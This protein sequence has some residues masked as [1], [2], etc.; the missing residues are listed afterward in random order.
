MAAFPDGRHRIRLVRNHEVR[1]SPGPPIEP[2]RPYDPLAGGGT[3]TVIV[4]TRTRLPTGGFVSLSGTHTNCAGGPTPWGSWVT[5]EE[6]TLGTDA[7]FTKPH[8]YTF[9]IPADA[10][11]PVNPV[12]LTAMGRFV[13]EALAVDPRTGWVYET[14]DR[15]TSGIYRFIPDRPRR[16]SRGGTLEMLAVRGQPNYDTR[17]GQSVGERHRIKWVPIAEPDP[18]NAEA[19]PLA[20]FEQGHAGGG[21]I[22]SRL[23]GAWYGDGSIFF[24]ATD[25][26]DLHLGQVWELRPHGH[27]NNGDLELIYESNDPARLDSPDNITVS[28]RGGLVLCEDG[29]GGDQYLR[30][31]TQRGRIFD[32]AKNIHPGFEDSEFAGATFT[33]HGETL[34]VN[35]QTPGVT[36]GIWGPWQRGSLGPEEHRHWHNDDD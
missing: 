13:H 12:K 18:S 6:T 19:N 10:N 21:A 31:L 23:E 11:G 8:G 14:E 25:G 29:G 20:V 28:P 22:F 9:E 36:L 2:S 27:S 32:F 4:D 1:N 3:T 26:G 35:I 24:H 17:T 15:G 33:P 7:G 5:C 34:F 30:G 16:L